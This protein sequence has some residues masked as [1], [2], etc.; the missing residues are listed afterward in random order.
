LDGGFGDSLVDGNSVLINGNSSQLAIYLAACRPRPEE[1][2]PLLFF[3]AEVRLFQGLRVQPLGSQHAESD[4]TAS[5]VRKL[6]A[7]EK[8]KRKLK[9]EVGGFF[10]HEDDVGRLAAA[11]EARA[12]FQRTSFGEWLDMPAAERTEKLYVVS[13]KDG[14]L[15]GL[16]GAL[17]G[18]L[19]VAR[20]P[21]GLRSNLLAAALLSLILVGG[22]AAWIASV[23]AQ[24]QA[25]L[26]A[27]NRLSGN[28]RVAAYAA[29][30]ESAPSGEAYMG[31]A[32]ALEESQAYAGALADYE[33]A[34]K[35]QPGNKY[36]WWG[37]VRCSLAAG[38]PSL[39]I[40]LARAGLRLFPGDRDLRSVRAMAYSLVGEHRKAE[41]DF[42]ATQGVNNNRLNFAISEALSLQSSKKAIA[43]LT[44]GINGPQPTA[45]AFHFRS[46][47]YERQ[48]DLD[49]AETDMTIALEL[50]L[51]EG[52]QITLL[53]RLALGRM[54]LALRD[55]DG[56]I[57]ILAPPLSESPHWRPG[58]AIRALALACL[59]R[60]KESRQ[61][62]KS[63]Q[64]LPVSDTLGVLQ[65][66]EDDSDF[67]A[68]QAEMKLG[69][70]D[71]ALQLIQRLSTAVKPFAR[72][73][74][75]RAKIYRDLGK[76][77]EAV[78]DFGKAI[79]LSPTDPKPLA[80]YGE[81]LGEQ[82]DY[83]QALKVLRRARSMPGCPSRA[84]LLEAA[85][86]LDSG[87][88]QAAI[89]AANSAASSGE[90]LGALE[91]R[92]R[93]HEADRRLD[94]A[95]RDLS[96][97]MQF[98]PSTVLRNERGRLLWERG[99]RKGA[100]RDWYESVRLEVGSEDAYIW[101]IMGLAEIG[102]L[103]EAEAL[104]DQ[105]VQNAP[106]SRQALHARAFLHL[107][108]ERFSRASQD[109]KSS[110]LLDKKD[111]PSTVNLAYSL[112]RCG[113]HE[114]AES[115]VA[116]LWGFKDQEGVVV[117]RAR[118]KS[119]WIPGRRAL[120]FLARSLELSDYIVP[121]DPEW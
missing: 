110:W 35:C 87:Q 27:A 95:T 34:R 119:L 74:L 106:G 65:E 42:R 99:D 92:W 104:A 112:A 101:L 116:A 98:E 43:A 63:Y 72:L 108:G 8:A 113:K 85:L 7:V 69:E 46:L 56:A 28:A 54:R 53:R 107:N 90:L 60:T 114:Q 82:E 30:I 71:R 96:Q 102:S 4:V 80:D 38:D 18:P 55:W 77:D 76:V 61:I 22:A 25:D 111:V 83:G 97:L 31:R 5:L 16:V 120:I 33:A 29:L 17:G 51:E 67:Y 58:L 32:G 121:V 21:Q 68:A 13:L 62:L 6:D 2:A 117:V 103:R 109:F 79:A 3:S 24:R 93:A 40:D 64:A 14:D 115:L 59:G 88:A 47:L 44:S 78:S 52:K 41:S 1:S 37:A 86:L 12:R 100:I 73:Y 94:L 91:V 70:P 66:S 81:F 11:G 20:G 19:G 118:A 50:G 84:N 36:A 39:S 105:L 89:A 26:E 9:V 23:R 57:E 45:T 75:V 48:G 15:S 10:L 49:N